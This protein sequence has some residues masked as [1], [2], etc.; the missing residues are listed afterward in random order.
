MYDYRSKN[1]P[2]SSSSQLSDPFEFKDAH[3]AAYTKN[4]NGNA[5]T[6]SYGVVGSSK[7]DYVFK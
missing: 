4:E 6:K 1:R 2:L 7:G 5:T 3:T